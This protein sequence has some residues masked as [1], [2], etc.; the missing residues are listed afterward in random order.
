MMRCS[1][2]VARLLPQ[3]C[4]VDEGEAREEEREVMEDMLTPYKQHTDTIKTL[5]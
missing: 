5:Y 2:N 3:C 4:H 1:H